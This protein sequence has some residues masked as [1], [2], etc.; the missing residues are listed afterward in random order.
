MKIQPRDAESWIAKPPK[1]LRAVLMY[2]ENAGLARELADRI[3]AQI[4]PDARDK[5]RIVELAASD[6]RKDP[7]RLSDEAAQMSMF[8]PGR[9]VLRV[10]DAS[11][12]MGE[13][14]GDFLQSSQGDALVVVEAAELT[15]RAS[16]RTV[17]EGHAQAAAIACYE[18]TPD[19]V[20]ELAQ[21]LLA[22]QKI[23]PAP[24]ALEAVLSRL[25]LDR[26]VLRNE[27]SKLDLFFG[28]TAE[29]TLTPEL[30][31]E[32]FGQAGEVEASEVSAA[33]AMGDI[34]ALDHMLTKAEEAGASATQLVTSSLRHLHALLAAKAHG[35]A[36]GQ[37]VNIARQ[38]GLWG[39]S[40][41]AIRAQLRGW[42]LERLTAAVRVLGQAE[43]D[44]RQT[45]L[46]DWPIASRALLHAA[47]LA[48]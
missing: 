6:L 13:L 5:E 39:Q 45:S 12:A 47:R 35:E 43:G 31:N 26:R 44:T 19:T 8:S 21:S 28:N 48:K 37:D 41:M 25:G 4:V 11:E 16:L 32:L 33:V 20:M 27:M 2:G 40:D 10:R 7:A 22:A 34:R 36:G 38:R 29:R 42:S 14:F 18:D 9:R 17:F 15:A 23:K 30:V 46:P 1:N 24:G 3:T